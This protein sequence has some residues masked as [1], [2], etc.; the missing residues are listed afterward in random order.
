[1]A[2]VPT[3][4]SSRVPISPK[5]ALEDA[6]QDFQSILSNDQRITL[7]KI[8]IVPDADAVITFT[9]QL[10]YSSRSRKGRSIASRLHPLLQSVREFSTIVDTFVSS[11]PGVAAL[12]WG[13]IKLTMLVSAKGDPCVHSKVI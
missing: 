6:L 12:V 3:H 8:K 2:L 5:K 9:A 1:M 4:L 13:S 11:N 7:Q 10:D